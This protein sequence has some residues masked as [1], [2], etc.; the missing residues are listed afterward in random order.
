MVKGILLLNYESA[1]SQS[2]RKS[3]CAP[4]ILKTV[5]QRCCRLFQEAM[6]QAKRKRYFWEKVRGLFLH[7]QLP[8][9]ETL[10]RCIA[11]DM[12]PTVPVPNDSW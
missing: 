11:Y 1:M 7:Y 4:E 12:Q 5:R 2:F 9:W 3:L 10:Y 6:E 8:D